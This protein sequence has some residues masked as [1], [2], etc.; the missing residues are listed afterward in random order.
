MSQDTHNRCTSLSRSTM[1]SC[2]P[3]NKKAS[4]SATNAASFSR[5]NSILISICGFTQA[6]S[7]S[8]VRYVQRLS[9]KSQISTSIWRPTRFVLSD[10]ACV[11]LSTQVYFLY[12]LGMEK[13]PSQPEYKGWA[14][15]L[16]QRKPWTGIKTQSEINF[17][18]LNL[19]RRPNIWY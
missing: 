17:Q 18:L 6:K 10:W 11:Y 13:R 2:G 9:P 4:I 15:S 19:Y 12:I 8:S 7:L 14:D 16:V 5:K 1:P 3:L